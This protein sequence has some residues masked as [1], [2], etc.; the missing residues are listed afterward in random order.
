MSGVSVAT[1]RSRVAAAL[2]TIEG[3]TESRHP[4]DRFGRD[5]SQLSHRCFAVAV[6]T[7]TADERRQRRSRGVVSS[8]TVD[9]HW[10][11]RLRVDAVVPDTTEGLEAEELLTDA[12]FDVV[13]RDQITSITLTSADRSST[14]EGTYLVGRVR[15]RV[16]HRLPLILE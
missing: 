6:P 15:V 12:I 8:T 16:V 11:W 7:T 13:N 3:W 10:S 1:I 5:T 4:P 9:V 14:D 2:D